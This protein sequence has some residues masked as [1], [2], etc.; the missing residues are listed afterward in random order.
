M[1]DDEF[2]TQLAKVRSK[3]PPVRKHIDAM[4]VE[5][6]AFIAVGREH[7]ASWLWDRAREAADQARGDFGAGLHAQ[8]GLRDP[9][10][11]W[12]IFVLFVAL[13]CAAFSVALTAGVRSEPE[14][15]AQILAVLVA[16]A[17]VGDLVV[18]IAVG[19]R[20]L[21]WGTA[22]IQVAIGVV[23]AAAAAFQLARPVAPVAPLVFG[24]GLVG[25]LGLVLVLLVRALRPAER[26]EV[27]AA[28]NVALVK[29]K[30]EVDAAQAQLQDDV[31]AQLSG[32]ERARIVAL[33]DAAFA[34]LAEEGA[35]LRRPHDGAPAGSAI[36]TRM[37]TSWVPDSM[38]SEVY[39]D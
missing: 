31:S 16:I 36:L 19:F 12:P 4:P 2:T 37:I 30:I 38:R 39:P 21:N 3:V 9:R 5:Q 18:M 28:I 15:T 10:R 11:G 27:D 1:D 26:E 7:L 13:L 24:A 17:G 33:R 25:I 22:R 34:E 8:Y 32:D 23:L 29:T 6:A 20:P 14:G 35:A